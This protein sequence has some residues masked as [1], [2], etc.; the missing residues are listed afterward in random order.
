MIKIFFLLVTL[1]N[2]QLINIFVIL[3]IFC[4]VYIFFKFE[5][6]SSTNGNT[7]LI[8]KMVK[9]TLVL[10]LV[11]SLIVTLNFCSKGTNAT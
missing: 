7:Y 6:V 2:A 1:N 3:T 8:L 4:L 10:V 5:I 11:L 9:T